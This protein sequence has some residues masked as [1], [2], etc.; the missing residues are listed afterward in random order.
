VEA[1]I[2][3]FVGAFMYAVIYYFINPNGVAKLGEQGNNF[4]LV[5]NDLI[6]CKIQIT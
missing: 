1:I 2:C 6:R 4:Y 5:D 3:G